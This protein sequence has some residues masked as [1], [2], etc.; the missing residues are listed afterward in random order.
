MAVQIDWGAV[1]QQR[2]PQVF[3]FFCYR[4]GDESL[5]EDLT[6]TT[7]EKAW[8]GRERYREDLGAFSSW[9][10]GIARKVAADHYRNRREELP[11]DE[12][13]GLASEGSVEASAQKNSNFRR[14]AALLE[15]LPPRERELL[16]L[17][18]GAEVTNRGIAELTGLSES[19]VGT[20]LHRVVKKLRAEWE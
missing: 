8:S 12:N 15:R 6:A 13:R 9:L 10:F 19:N 11:L 20:I 18:Y 1:Y 2:L 17:K 7:F 4:L 3:H 14:L 5:A 16:A